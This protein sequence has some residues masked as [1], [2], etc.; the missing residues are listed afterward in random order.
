MIRIQRIRCTHCGHT[1][2]VLPSFLLA[3]KHYTVATL[4]DLVALFIACPHG[5]SG[6][7][8]ITVDISTAYRWLR[9]LTEQACQ[10]LPAIRKALLHLAPE[11][12]LM[13]SADTHPEPVGSRSVVLRRLVCLAERLFEAAVRLAGNN[14]SHCS[15]CYCFLNH[16]LAHTTGKALLVR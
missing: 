12:P 7:P 5:W 13:D 11:H 4:K 1:T 14:D 10:A 9:I 3:Q 16:F 15:D 6:S 2:N 8:E